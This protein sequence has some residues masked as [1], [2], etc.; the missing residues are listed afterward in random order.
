MPGIMEEKQEKDFIPMNRNKQWYVIGICAAI[1]FFACKKDNQQQQSPIPNVPV[2]VTLNLDLPQYI[3]LKNQGFWIYINGGSRGI[4]VYHGY[5]DLFYAYDRNCPY[6]PYDSCAQVS[7]L[8][9]YVYLQCGHYKSD[10]SSIFV[11][12]CGSKFF[13]EY[14]TLAEGPAQHGLKN[15]NVTK[16]GSLIQITN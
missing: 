14:G 11:K 12:C 13:L 15:Y 5:D 9:D 6:Q 2:N 3:A 16:S 8:N 4:V 7:V 10:T 1:L